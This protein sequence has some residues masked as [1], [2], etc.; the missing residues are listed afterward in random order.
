MAQSLGQIT[1]DAWEQICALSAYG[2]AP[3]TVGWWRGE[4][5]VHI[6]DFRR[7]AMHWRRLHTARPPQEPQGQDDVFSSRWL[8]DHLR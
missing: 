5:Y 1:V 7:G 2:S 8:Y 6:W 4:A 3:M